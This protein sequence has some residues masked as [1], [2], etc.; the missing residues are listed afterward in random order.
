MSSF[1]TGIAPLFTR[2][3][4]QRSLVS[5]HSTAQTTQFASTAH[6]RSDCIVHAQ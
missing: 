6:H 3:T 1:N 5:V 2:R 4:R